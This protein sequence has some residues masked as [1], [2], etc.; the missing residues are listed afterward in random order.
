MRF[1]KIWAWT[2]TMLVICAL[3][4]CIASS[5]QRFEDSTTTTETFYAEDGS[6]ASTIVTERTVRGHNRALAPPLGAKAIAN[7]RLFMDESPSAEGTAWQVDM[8]Q[9]SE[10]EGGDL[11]AAIEAAG[12]VM[13]EGVLEALLPVL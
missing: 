9:A 13:M 2:V 1:S 5:S 11:S 4:A 8:G 3:N 7:H 6:V 10:L 12:K